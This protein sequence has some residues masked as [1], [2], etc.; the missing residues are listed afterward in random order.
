MKKHL[1]PAVPAKPVDEVRVKNVVKYQFPVTVKTSRDI[2]TLIDQ[3]GNP[4]WVA[5]EVCDILGYAN[6]SKAI[7]DHCKYSELFR[8]NES[9][10]LG[11]NP[12]GVLIIPESDVY[13]LIMRSKVPAAEKFQDWVTE[14]VLPLIRKTGT[15]TAPQAAAAP[16]PQPDTQPFTI[17]INLSADAC[18]QILTVLIGAMGQTESDNS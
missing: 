4:W 5:K 2:T 3:N 6:T 14:E 16:R 7:S 9:L 18:A 15:Y 13:R 12:R 8:S 1:K 11:F 10:Y 17:N